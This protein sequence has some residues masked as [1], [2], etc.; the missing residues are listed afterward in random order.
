[1]RTTE[2]ASKAY[3]TQ[4]LWEGKRVT[5]VGA[6]RSGIGAAELLLLLGARVTLTDSAPKTGTALAGL[7]ERGVSLV[8]GKHPREVFENADF[9]CGAEPILN[10][11]EEAVG[12]EA[13]TFEVENRVDDVFQNPGA[14]DC[15]FFRYMA[16]QKHRQSGSLGDLPQT[17][18]T[19]PHLG[20]RAGRR[21]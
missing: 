4:E 10:R 21:F 13:V 11:T 18:S 12:L 5:V 19:F 7:A 17:G 15:P 3:G 14:G 16:D 8:L 20:H 2:M 1:M 9:G 6:A